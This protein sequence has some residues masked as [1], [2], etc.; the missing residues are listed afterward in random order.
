MSSTKVAMMHF[1][2]H[3]A[4]GAW[5]YHDLPIC[6]LKKNENGLWLSTFE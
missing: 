4:F 2:Q 3:I 6:H 1:V 5:E